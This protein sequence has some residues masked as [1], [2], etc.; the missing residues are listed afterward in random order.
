MFAESVGHQRNIFGFAATLR[1][2]SYKLVG[3]VPYCC[4]MATAGGELSPQCDAGITSGGTTSKYSM[5]QYLPS[6]SLPVVKKLLSYKKGTEEDDEEKWSEKAVKSLVKKLK[7][8]GGLSELEKAITSEGKILTSCVTIARSLDGRLQVSH[9]KG[10]PH[11]I[12][13]RLWRWPDLQNHHELKA[14]ESCQFAFNLKRDD[15]CINPYHYVRVETP[16]L[17]PVLVPTNIQHTIPASLPPLD[18]TVPENGGLCSSSD[19][20]ASLF[21]ETPPPAYGETEYTSTLSSP[22]PSQSTYSGIGS[23]LLSPT[24]SY[25][26]SVPSP[27]PPSA[28]SA[29]SPYPSG[30][31]SLPSPYAPSS[32]S[33][34]SPYPSSLQSTS[35]PSPSDF[36]AVTYCEPQSWCSV[37]YYEM[38]N[39]VGE[40]FNAYKPSLTIDGGTDPSSPERFCLG[41]LSNVNRD[42]VIEQTRRHIGQG[43]R[44]FY[45]GG[46]VWAECLSDSSIFVQSPNANLRQGWHPATVCKIPPGCHLNIFNNQ[47]F[48]RRLAESVHLGFEAVYQLTKMCTIRISFVK[49]WGAEYRRP[50]VTS[51]P[52]WIEIHLNGS[53]QWLDKV[54]TQMGS[55]EGLIR[56]DT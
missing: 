30:S 1:M 53:F 43:V 54:L 3:G 44:L 55:P 20:P 48:A 9:R 26:A 6:F 4:S 22:A 28:H 56:S 42:S 17:P 35:S 10:L 7:K 33:V 50:T 41:L 29:A 12:Y 47:D 52:C 34:P 25:P 49:G 37:N 24:S 27:Y 18:D 21:P 2:P 23:P 13:C 15:V 39:R 38:K 8:S 14:I 51:T 45:V 11:V 16:V 40:V 32:S 19:P 31:N 5:S 46:E 36:Q